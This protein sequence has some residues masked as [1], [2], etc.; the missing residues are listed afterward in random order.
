MPRAFMTSPAQPS[1]SGITTTNPVLPR[2]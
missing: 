1:A 2:W